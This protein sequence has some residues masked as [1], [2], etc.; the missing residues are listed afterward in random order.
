MPRRDGQEPNL[1]RERKSGHGTSA[2]DDG[3]R[4]TA[5]D[6]AR[7]DGV[8]GETR[9]VV[10]VELLPD[11]LPVFF[12]RFGVDAQF[13]RDLFDGLAL[14]NQREHRHFARTQ[15]GSL[16][17]CLSG[18]HTWDLFRVGQRHGEQQIARQNRP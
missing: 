13:R 10:D 8:A 12:N 16:L 2:L 3:Q 15:A 18:C 4:D 14:G 11:T 9:R 5:S 6:D 1:R 7:R 17:P